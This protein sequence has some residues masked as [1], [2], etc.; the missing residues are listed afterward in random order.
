MQ[1]YPALLS[2][3]VGKPG[4]ANPLWEFF[5]GQGAAALVP[6]HAWCPH[7]L[8]AYPALARRVKH[9]RFPRDCL[10]KRKAVLPD[11]GVD[12]S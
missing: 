11:H 10:A 4:T 12:L 3:S 9:R 1:V 5:R 6:V 7:H 2:A 8:R